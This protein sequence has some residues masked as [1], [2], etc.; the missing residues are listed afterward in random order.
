LR[1]N[2]EIKTAETRKGMFMI[3]NRVL[4]RK[5]VRKAGRERPDE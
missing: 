2:K 4:H 5:G 3:L 1:E